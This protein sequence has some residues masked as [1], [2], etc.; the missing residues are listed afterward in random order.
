ALID[1]PLAVWQKLR[2]GLPDPALG[3]LGHTPDPTYHEH[4]AGA[5]L[6]SWSATESR[7]LDRPPEGTAGS[8]MESD[9]EPCSHVLQ[10]LVGEQMLGAPNPS[11]T[12]CYTESQSSPS[13]SLYTD[14]AEGCE[15][16]T[17]ATAADAKEVEVVLLLRALHMRDRQLS[18]PSGRISF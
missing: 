14:G 10:S 16:D 2:P 6:I 12:L 9:T 3:L 4:V 1:Q 17:D 18:A 5:L 13:Q 7:P 11:C 8:M 15:V